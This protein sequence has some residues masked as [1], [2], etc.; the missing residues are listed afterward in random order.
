M[1]K[2]ISKLN[3]FGEEYRDIVVE[4]NENG[5]FESGYIKGIGQIKKTSVAEEAINKYL[6][7]EGG[8]YLKRTDI[9]DNAIRIHGVKKVYEAAYK[10][11]EGDKRPLRDIE[12][13]AKGIADVW[14]IM[15]RAFAS[16]YENKY[17]REKEK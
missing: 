2:V 12:L 5:L 8:K 1:K 9:I 15:Q 11:M 7:T 4:T 17:V 13:E 3:I 6:K 10:Q 14:Q 16:V